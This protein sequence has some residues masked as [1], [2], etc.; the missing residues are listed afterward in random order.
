MGYINVEFLENPANARAVVVRDFLEV[1]SQVLLDQL[2]VEVVGLD[3]VEEIIED[4]EVRE[5]TTLVAMVLQ[6]KL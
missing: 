3:E 5:V 4:E 6:S 1:L 2:L